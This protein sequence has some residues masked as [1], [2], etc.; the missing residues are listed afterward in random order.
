MPVLL[1]QGPNLVARTR[2][3]QS[4]HINLTTKGRLFIVWCCVCLQMV[5]GT[6]MVGL[7]I[8]LIIKSGKKNHITRIE[9]PKET[10]TK[11]NGVS[12]RNADHHTNRRVIQQSK[13]LALACSRWMYHLAPHREGLFFPVTELAT[14][15]WFWFDEIRSL[16][17]SK[18]LCDSASLFP[19]DAGSKETPA[20]VGLF[21]FAEN[22][23]TEEDKT[24][25]ECPLLR[26]SCMP[27]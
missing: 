16:L 27:L 8:L 13:V 19:P 20:L 7:I 14:R 9:T 2:R 3:P 10:T 5:F 25:P 6:Q 4:S 24:G 17:I 12:R 11:K 21:T 18:V 23:F 22:I 26:S 15:S 1:R